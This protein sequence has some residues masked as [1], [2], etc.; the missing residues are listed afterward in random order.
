MQYPPR[1]HS[2]ASDEAI[3][4]LCQDYPF[5][6]LIT[7]P[8]GMIHVSSLPLV[9]DRKDGHIFR[10]RGHLNA[11]NPQC[12]LL[13]GERAIA[14]F[15]GPDAFISPFYRTQNDRGPTWDYANV[16]ISG[17]VSVRNDLEFFAKLV[18]DL[19][20]TG[21]NI[22]LSQDCPRWNLS[23][24]SNEYVGRLR[25]HLTAFEIAVDEVKAI[26]KFHQDFPVEDRISVAGHLLASSVDRFR[27]VGLE[28]EKYFK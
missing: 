2:E 9:A 16:T 13:D 17:H 18:E 23:C 11:A 1:P 24:V 26:S 10:V 4:R 14:V 5:A 21:E 28:I 6:N 3:A 27:Q 19:A 20:R 8:A 7:A 12:Q 22:W 15:N 25:P